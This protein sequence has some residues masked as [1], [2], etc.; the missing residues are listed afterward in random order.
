MFEIELNEIAYTAAT[1][2]YAFFVL[3]TTIHA[4]HLAGGLAFVEFEARLH[5]VGPAGH[6]FRGE[7]KGAVGRRGE[8]KLSGIGENAA[9][10]RLG[11]GGI[12]GQV[13]IEKEAGED[14]AGRRRPGIHAVV[15]RITAVR[16]MMIDVGK[17]L[18]ET[19]HERGAGAFMVGMIAWASAGILEKDLASNEFIGTR[20]LGTL[21]TWPFRT[22]IMI[23][24]AVAAIEF[25]AVAFSHF[26]S[27]LAGEETPHEPR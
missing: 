24:M 3:L 23:G 8:A 21:P 1:P 2:A 10:E 9:V 20:G 27:A 12:D 6:E 22:L 11:G 17:H 26:K 4:L 16:E 13:E 14:F 5:R 7:G 19:C 25:V 15:L 18:R